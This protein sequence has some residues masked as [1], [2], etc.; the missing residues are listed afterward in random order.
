MTAPTL[1]LPER[2]RAV[3]SDLRA[4]IGAHKVKDDYSTLTAYAV[5]ASIY[6]MEPKA[7]V[8][9]ESE[10]DIAATVRY[11]VERGIPLTPRAAGTNLTGSAIGSGIILDVSRLNRVLEMNREERWA[12]VQPGIVL[13]ELNKELGRH[14]L[15]F[16]PDPSSG[17]MCKLG[18]MLAN[19]SSGPHTLRYGA[20]KDNVAA[21]RVCL[22]SGDRS[23]SVV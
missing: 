11:A 10:E 8:L 9:V 7:I 14:G 20:V 17:D 15:L 19:N 6:R 1:I 2:S 4:A 5:D 21:L 23:E 3:A 22:Q 16:G 18:G 12:R 13:A